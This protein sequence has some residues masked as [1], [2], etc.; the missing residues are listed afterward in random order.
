[1][2]YS[3]P[4]LSK[5]S[6]GTQLLP[7]ELLQPLLLSEAVSLCGAT[8]L[9][10]LTGNSLSWSPISMETGG[11]PERAKALYSR[12]VCFAFPEVFSAL[13]FAGG[14]LTRKHTVI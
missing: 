14:T 2:L 13:S 10:E 5:E 8:V 1:M 7:G 6:T 9:A 12:R 3:E 4:L 11:P